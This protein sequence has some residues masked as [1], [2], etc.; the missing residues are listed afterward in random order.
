MNY[1]IKLI[2]E[3]LLL[4]DCKLIKKNN[5]LYYFDGLCKVKALIGIIK[6]E[7]NPNIYYVDR[8]YIKYFIGNV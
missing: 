8:F 1:V 4:S 2:Y 3:E 7:A 5:K 6:L